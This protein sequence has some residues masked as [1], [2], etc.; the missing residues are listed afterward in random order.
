[1]RTRT[2]NKRRGD[3]CS[4]YR[5]STQGEC[6]LSPWLVND[7]DAVAWMNNVHYDAKEVHHIFG[8]GKSEGFES[9][10][11]LILVS[12]AAHMWI[13]SH[14][15][16]E[17]Q[18]ACLYAKFRKHQA[19]VER[20][21]ALGLKLLLIGQDRFEWCPEIMNGLVQPFAVLVGKLYHLLERCEK[22]MYCDYA[23]EILKSLEDQ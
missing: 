8:R 5:L 15:P 18:I 3:A 12:K 14:R 7:R 4:D 23:A 6:E 10:A 9:F 22:Q 19:R 16:I 17:G 13:E 11:N 20:L 21:A 2:Q 1:M